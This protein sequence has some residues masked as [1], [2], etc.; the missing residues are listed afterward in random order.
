M[1]IIN[2]FL[3]SL[4]GFL[5]GFH[6][7]LVHL[8]IGILLLAALFQL[9]S[10]NEKFQA[11]A[12]AVR[13]TL[14]LGM[15]SAIASCI[16][17]Y[18]LSIS[19]D[20]DENLI[21]NHQWFGIALAITS[22]GAWLLNRLNKNKSWV[23]ILMV[24]L[25]FITGHYGGSITH[26][27]GFLTKAFSS[28]DSDF[29]GQKREPIPNIQEALVYQ[30]VIKPILTSKC[31][32]CHG[33]NKQKGKLRLDIPDFILKGGK[34]GRVI[35]AG[36]TEES[37]LIKRIL[38]SKGND[39]HMPPIEKSQLTKAELD[40]I[41]WWVGSGADF[42]KKVNALVQT[43]KIKPV[44]LSLESEETPEAEKIASV[45]KQAVERADENAIKSLL[46]RGIA[47]FPVAQGNNYLSVNFVALDSI[48]NQDLKLLEPLSKQLVWLKLGDSN[49]DD[50]MLQEIGKLTV[51][52]HLYLQRTA[53]TDEGVRSLNR[54]SKLQYLNLVGT[55]VT[56]KG[57][58]Q[59][60]ELKELRKIFIYQTEVHAADFKQ[61][62]K[63]F[64]KAQIDTGGYKVQFLESDTIELKSAKLR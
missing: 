22:I 39:D 64:P 60:S 15:L 7:L 30:D 5:G 14:F 44:L 51:L 28:E 25:I 24:L 4:T 8:P 31:Y 33:P 61:L 13:I 47:V 46:N 56:A 52:T 1:S 34:G 58:T 37:E 18:F 20:Y 35:I 3:F 9:L 50:K 32:K 63:M 40:L 43:E 59:L 57:L 6:P 38:L 27:S 62:A 29:A 48:S 2:V 36:K 41:H 16:S 12:G 42:N 49:I 21:F 10:K 17:G 26:G 54:L 45:P 53:I 19:G 23:S 55:R 11:L